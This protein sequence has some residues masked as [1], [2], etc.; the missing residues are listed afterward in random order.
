M[1][2]SSKSNTSKMLLA[3]WKMKENVF[4]DT[5][6]MNCEELFDYIN[7]KTEKVISTLKKKEK[8]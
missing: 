3:V 6:H 4:K 7:R 1:N 8:V 5:Q 2:T